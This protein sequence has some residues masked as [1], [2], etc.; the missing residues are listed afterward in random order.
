MRA[1]VMCFAALVAPLSSLAEA[2]VAPHTLLRSVVKITTAEKRGSG[3]F[4][5]E[6][7]LVVTNCHVLSQFSRKKRHE[8]FTVEL[9]V[10]VS[11]PRTERVHLL[12]CGRLSYKG[13][14]TARDIAVI[15]LKRKMMRSTPLSVEAKE[16]EVSTGQVLAYPHGDLHI[17]Q[18]QFLHRYRESGAV[19]RGITRFSM[20]RDIGGRR[21]EG[22]PFVGGSSGGPVVSCKGKVVGMIVAS[23]YYREVFTSLVIDGRILSAELSRVLSPYGITAR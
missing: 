12:H 1:I 5:R 23:L 14:I 21:S 11:A 18:A 20:Y 22:F 19:V 6:K 9:T 13:E 2:C 16:T 15:L 8:E 10:G 17:A 4:F 3:W 7:D